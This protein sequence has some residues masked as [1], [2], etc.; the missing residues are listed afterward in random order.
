MTQ[1]NSPFLN[2]SHPIPFDLFATEQVVDHITQLLEEAKRDL[3]NIEDSQEITYDSILG[4]LD[5][6]GENLESCLTVY[7]QLESLLGT[8]ELREA[9][10][11][12]QP[13]VS[14][15]YATIPFSTALYQKLKALASSDSMQERSES[16]QR[17]LEQTLLSFQR[18]GAEAST[19][20]KVRLEEI[21]RQL[22]ELTMNFAKNVVEETDEFEWVCANQD[23]L[24]GLPESALASA[25]QSA[26]AKDLEGYRFTL[27]GPSYIAIMT[28]CDDRSLRE[29]FYRAYATRACSL[30]RNNQTLI[31]NILSLRQEKAS[32]LGYKDVSDLFL[33]SRMVKNG[34]KA[35]EF[36]NELIEKTLEFSEK[37]HQSLVNFAQEHLSWTD[38]IQAWDVSYI[39]EKQ[40][41]I[42]CGFDAEIL[43][44][45]FEV[46]SVMKGMFT[47]VEQLYQ[48]QVEPIDHIS[49]W[50]PDVMTFALKE[51]GET[52]GIFYADLFPREG[53]QGGAWMCP[54]LYKTE[55]QPHVGLICA[56]FTPPVGGVSLITHREVE[57]LFHEF[58]HLLHH[59]LTTVSVRSQ[60]GTN[61]AWD[62]VELP[63]Q[64]MENWCWER[65]ALN[66][67]AKHY[68][69]G[70]TMPNELF[71]QLKNTQKFRAASGQMRQLT[72]AEIDL[73]LHQD[74][75]FEAD[76]PVLA[77]AR[78]HMAKRASTP[79]PDDYAMIAGFTHLFAS[80]TGYAAAYYSYKWAEV[81]DA[82]AFTR[83]KDEGI[84]SATV[85]QAFREELLSLGDSQDPAQ[86]FENFMGRAPSTDA[87]FKRLGLVS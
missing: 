80:A 15:F 46:Q 43:K 6:L 53:K 51:N 87:L 2:L 24:T 77:Y 10:R 4:R 71:E 52:L 33:A 79:L 54:L 39:A 64:I 35:R 83:F 17:Y 21:E 1:I 73:K 5:R 20:T 74:Y 82:D 29:H 85:G 23:R 50:H 48:V 45:Y 13:Q 86:L 65:E 28:Y 63:S 37:E 32:L 9:M 84:F 61:V 18:N 7:S 59:L 31:H 8:S 70:E 27:Q 72:F 12:A 3:K 62:F 19:E 56:N 60:A 25:A 44:P 40:K 57:T 78:T 55:A 30:K 16:E 36:V 66:L 68:Q 11:Q 76:G 47:I 41:K 38:D 34:H 49:T 14:A 75:N 26:K 69:T 58:G 42:E 81:L 22:A 67:F